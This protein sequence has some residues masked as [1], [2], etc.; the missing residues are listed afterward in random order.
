MNVIKCILVN[1]ITG[2]IFNDQVEFFTCFVFEIQVEYQTVI[3]CSNKVYSYLLVCRTDNF[4][5]DRSCLHGS[6]TKG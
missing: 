3:R 6:G 5:D 1:D 4:F 2:I